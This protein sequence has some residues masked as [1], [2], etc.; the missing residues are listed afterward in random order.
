MPNTRPS[1]HATSSDFA[2]ARAQIE[3]LQAKELQS[4]DGATIN[5]VCYT[6]LFDHGQRT[7][8]VV[9]CYHG[10]TN[11]PFQFQ[12]LA[13]HFHAQGDNVFVP[14]L[15]YHG[16]RDRM[17]AEQARLT[18]TDLVDVTNETVDIACGLGEEI[19]LT[20]LS[21]GAVMAAWAAQFR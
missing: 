21:A 19:I 9:V 17:S 8:R 16:L 3:A 18:V 5:P 6:R 13:E 14:R 20:G 4:H 12:A 10:Y 7:R 1:S 2:V 15:P 11:C